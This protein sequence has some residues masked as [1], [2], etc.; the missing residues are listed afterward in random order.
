MAA[1]SRTAHR[2]LVGMHPSALAAVG[3]KGWSKDEY[4]GYLHLVEQLDVLDTICKTLKAVK[5]APKNTATALSYLVRLNEI[6]KFKS[7]L[8][9]WENALAK[10]TDA[11]VTE[12]SKVK[13]RIQDSIMEARRDVA[14][15]IPVVS[16][17]P[18]AR[19]LVRSSLASGLVHKKIREILWN[20]LSRG[21]VS[22][23]YIYTD[24]ACDLECDFEKQHFIIRDPTDIL[25]D[26]E[27]TR[28]FSQAL[29]DKVLLGLFILREHEMW[30]EM[31]RVFREEV[32]ALCRTTSD[33]EVTEKPISIPDAFERA[34]ARPEFTHLQAKKCEIFSAVCEQQQSITKLARTQLD[35]LNGVKA[36]QMDPY[37]IQSLLAENLK[38]I[39]K[40]AH[41]QLAQFNLVAA[42]TPDG[43]QCI[44]TGK[45]EDK[46]RALV[47]DCFKQ[48]IPDLL[49]EKFLEPEDRVEEK[50]TKA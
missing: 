5:N 17:L 30:V 50:K 45:L 26:A 34:L 35:H 41:T 46:W 44:F 6:E 4:A 23:E 43:D 16:R 24:K 39:V 1:V 20:L 47:R 21:P 19:H 10:P 15:E 29:N 37:D 32:F 8:E 7:D 28:A 14:R 13:S 3:Q 27:T 12:A 40:M 22:F 49:R 25:R 11:L 18:E 31:H 9:S 48:P 38:W 36:P 33:R 2:Y 42:P